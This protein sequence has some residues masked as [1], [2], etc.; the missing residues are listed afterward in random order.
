MSDITLFRIKHKQ[1]TQIESSSSKLEKNLQELIESNLETLLGVR[2]LKSEHSTGKVHGGRIDTL[3]LDE[4]NCPVIIEYK[5]TSS[6][7]V[8]NQ[9]LFYLDWLMDHQAEFQILVMQNLSAEDSENI[10]WSA[11]RLICIASD[12][13]KYDSHAVQQINRNI[14]LIR[15]RQFGDELFLLELISAVSASTTPTASPKK[16]MSKKT[17]ATDDRTAIQNLE[18]MPSTL[19]EVFK[20]LEDFA[21]SLGEDVQRKNLKYYI[22]FKRIKNLFCT[23]PTNNALRVYVRVDPKKHPLKK[24][25]AEDYTNKGHWGTGDLLIIIKN[26]KTLSRSCLQGISTVHSTSDI[27]PNVG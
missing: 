16:P 4:N 12:F 9:G 3:G 23:V 18:S 21:L 27:F 24:G 25:F 15:Y 7:N 22:A 13:N 2:F 26:A 5:R 1:A 10:D 6:E 11:P 14:E 19:Q 17:A 8:I 20:D